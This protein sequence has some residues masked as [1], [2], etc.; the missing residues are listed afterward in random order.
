MC[1]CLFMC[2]PF[3]SQ[4]TYKCFTCVGIFIVVL[5]LYLVLQTSK[6]FMWSQN[7]RSKVGESPV[8][9]C[10]R[11]SKGVLSIL[12]WWSRTLVSHSVSYLSR[13]IYCL[14]YVFGKPKVLRREYYSLEKKFLSFP[15]GRQESWTQKSGKELVN[16]RKTKV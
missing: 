12:Y 2:S 4:T 6:F 16:S 3:I 5:V 10:T 14:I 1:V 11:L 7:Y 8:K 15:T 9:R 13:E